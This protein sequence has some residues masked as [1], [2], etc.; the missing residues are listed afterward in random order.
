MHRYRYVV[1]IAAP[2]FAVVEEL[3]RV[4]E[5]IAGSGLQHLVEGKTA[6]LPV[7][8]GSVVAGHRLVELLLLILLLSRL[9]DIPTRMLALWRWRILL[10]IR[11]LLTVARLL[12]WLTVLLRHFENCLR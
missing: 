10:L 12:W 7:E 8:E 2:P 5:D 3:R 9:W 4:G 11:L 1:G 6:D